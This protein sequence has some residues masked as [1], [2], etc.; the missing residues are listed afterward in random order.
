LVAG[1]KDTNEEEAQLQKN[2]AASQVKFNTEKVGKLK[3]YK[4]EVEK[5]SRM[6]VKEKDRIV[7]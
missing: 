2:L 1:Q 6:A 7:R 5:S 3:E 4:E